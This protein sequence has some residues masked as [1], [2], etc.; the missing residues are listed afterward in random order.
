MAVGALEP[1]FYA[2]FI[3]KLGVSDEELPHMDDFEEG[4]KKLSQ[5]F[6]EK[7]QQEWCEIFDGSSACVTPVLTLESAP[8]H[9]HNQSQDNFIPGKDNLMVPAP[10]P[11]LSRTPG[12]SSTT[13]SANIKSGE[14]TREILKDF[15]FLDNE[16][17]EF[18]AKSV[19]EQLPKQSKL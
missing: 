14:H 15:H 7:S 17:E 1:Q 11:K 18:I 12:I 6:K 4:K 5:I 10:A 16:I 8:T 19:V 2:E 3:E 13:K 9:P